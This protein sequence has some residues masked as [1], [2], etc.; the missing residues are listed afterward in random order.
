MPIDAAVLVPPRDLN[1]SVTQVSKKLPTEMLEGSRCEISQLGDKTGPDF[2][3][4]RVD[5]VSQTGSG[6]R[7]DASIGILTVVGRDSW[8]PLGLQSSAPRR[9]DLPDPTL[10]AINL[11]DI[12]KAL[13]DPLDQVGPLPSG[14]VV[15]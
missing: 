4:I 2:L 8:N 13:P 5:E 3:C 10:G 7:H 9:C 14:R 12:Y 11:A 15:L 6:R 1:V